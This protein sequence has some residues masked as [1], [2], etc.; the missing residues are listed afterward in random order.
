MG[1]DRKQSDAETKG[2]KVVKLIR[3]IMVAA[4]L[5]GPD[6][7]ANPRLAHAVEKTRKA[8]VRG[9][10]I[11]R[12][13]RKGSGQ[14]DEKAGY[15]LVTYTGFT[16][17]QVPVVVECLTENPSRTTAEIQSLFRTGSLGL[18]RSVDTFFHRLGVVE[19]VHADPDRDARAEAARADVR[20]IE[21]LTARE[22]PAGWS[23][24]RF[25]T[26]IDDIDVVTRVLRAG[27]WNVL[28]SEVR[29]RPRDPAEL[30]E[31]ARREVA[32]FLAAL[33]SHDEVH[34]VYAALK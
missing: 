24:A 11:E 34:R 22:I 6:P 27:G 15:E 3:E 12:A 14:A 25:L 9:E 28:V 32:D 23:G 8:A 29:Y 26:E 18:P 5:C 13:I 7:A 21:P 30:D 16:P 17:H 19:A 33:E 2:Q 10:T 4:R 31:A 1:M 20:A